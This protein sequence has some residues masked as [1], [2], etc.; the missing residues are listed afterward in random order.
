MITAAANSRLLQ[1]VGQAPGSKAMIQMQIQQN[2]M[3]I[4][5]QAMLLHSQQMEQ[6]RNQQA[7][8]MLVGSALGG[9]HHAPKVGLELPLPATRGASTLRREGNGC[10]IL[11][12][13]I[14]INMHRFEDINRIKGLRGAS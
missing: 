10:E 11:V 2:Q 8:S 4:Q 12:G 5:Q 6:R 14:G 7:A 3:Q 1:T 9:M 13:G